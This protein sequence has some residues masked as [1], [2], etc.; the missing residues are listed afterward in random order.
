MDG[1]KEVLRLARVASE[2]DLFQVQDD[3]GD[4]LHDAFDRGEFVHGAID[5]DRSDG[6]PLERREQNSAQG[7]A[8]RKSITGLKGLGDEFGVSFCAVASSLVNRLGISK[9]PNR[10]GISFLA[11]LN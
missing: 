2:E 1:K 3:F 10:T 6:G 9:R 11:I 7:V 8:D 5:F 4:I